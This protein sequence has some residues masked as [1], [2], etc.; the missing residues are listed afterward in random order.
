[1]EP[2][3]MIEIKQ[4]VFG[5]ND[6]QAEASRQWLKTEK[7]LLL[8]LMSSPDSDKTNH[9][10]A[11]YRKAE[12]QTAHRDHGSRYRGVRGVREKSKS[13]RNRHSHLGQ[14]RRGD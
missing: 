12:E 9:A 10:V 3:R 4:G 8:N 7:T 13:Q 5:D 14:D 6:R 1:M 11:H 2:Y